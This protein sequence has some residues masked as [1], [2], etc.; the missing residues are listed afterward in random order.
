MNIKHLILI[1]LLLARAV[2]QHVVASSNR[3]NGGSVSKSYTPI[4]QPIKINRTNDVIYYFD[5]SKVH[6]LISMVPIDSGMMLS[7]SKGHSPCIF[8]SHYDLK[9]GMDC[10]TREHGLGKVLSLKE[11]RMRA[12]KKAWWQ[13]FGTKKSVYQAFIDKTADNHPETLVF[14]F[15]DNHCEVA[16]NDS[17]ETISQESEEIEHKNPVFS[18]KL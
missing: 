4:N 2:Q 17:K 6:P 14:V 9:K 11:I 5:A 8:D 1:L 16:E 3:M 13:I 7:H 12:G 10:Y 15:D 18:I